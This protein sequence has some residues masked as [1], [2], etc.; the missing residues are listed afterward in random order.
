[1]PWFA[2]LA[3]PFLLSIGFDALALFWG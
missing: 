1:V 2:L 3:G